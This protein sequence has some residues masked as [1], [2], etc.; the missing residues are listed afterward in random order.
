MIRGIDLDVVQIKFMA[1]AS[2]CGAVITRDVAVEYLG[3]PL[4]VL[5]AAFAGAGLILS[6]LPPRVDASGA[7]AGRLRTLGTVVFCTLLSAYTAS[8]LTAWLAG[9]VSV[10]E[11]ADMIV[12]FVAAAL[13]QVTIPLVIADPKGA[14]D[15]L[16]GLLPGRKS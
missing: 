2:A 4:P 9:Q 15:A 8:R 5:L 11:H 6:F 7:E 3:M 1:L 13:W 12:A 16:V 14:W 10:F